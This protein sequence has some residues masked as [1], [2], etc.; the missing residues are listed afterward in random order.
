MNKPIKT[1]NI[2]KVRPAADVFESE[3]AYQIVLD[4]VGVE[5]EQVALT[6]EQETLKITGRRESKVSEPVL[7]EREFGVPSA[8]D[9]DAV[10]ANYT[11][12]VLT[13]TLP[14]HPSSKPRRISVAVS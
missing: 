14:K 2:R 13:V 1:E 4:L 10:A 12:G 5:R 6:L 3:N 7:Y 9:R 11:A 8:I